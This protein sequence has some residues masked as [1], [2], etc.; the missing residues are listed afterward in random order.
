M[1]TDVTRR[2]VSIKILADSSSF[3]T[4]SGVQKFNGNFDDWPLAPNTKWTLTSSS[5]DFSAESDINNGKFNGP[6]K[7]GSLTIGQITD[8]VIYVNGQEVSLY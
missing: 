2:G 4:F 6:L 1:T 7:K 8:N 3:V 5:G